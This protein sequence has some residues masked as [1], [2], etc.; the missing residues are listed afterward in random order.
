VGSSHCYR[1]EGVCPEW[2]LKS[3][4]VVGKGKYRRCLGYWNEGWHSGR[5]DCQLSR[6]Y[7]HAWAF[8]HAVEVIVEEQVSSNCIPVFASV[9]VCSL[10][11][12]L[13]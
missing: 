3:T 13:V 9:S 7:C 4:W 11:G 10:L 12:I 1:S 2:I 6:K 8:S 5:A